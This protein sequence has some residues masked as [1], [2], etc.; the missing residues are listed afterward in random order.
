[1]PFIHTGSVALELS[2]DRTTGY[3]PLAINLTFPRQDTEYINYYVKGA[4]FKITT[5][6]TPVTISGN[7]SSSI[8]VPVPAEWSQSGGPNK[9]STGAFIAGVLSAALVVAVISLSL[10]YICKRTRRKREEEQGGEEVPKI[11]MEEAPPT[12]TPYN[13]NHY[14]HHHHR[15]S[16]RVTTVNHDNNNNNDPREEQSVL[17]SPEETNLSGLADTQPTEPTTEYLPAYAGQASPRPQS[18]VST[19]LSGK[20]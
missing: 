15:K 10:I 1:S 16:S 3:V 11:E 6:T 9:I 7:N 13:I 8:N 2:A 18:T 19:L 5:P 14:H 17:R 20:L 12:P 4:S